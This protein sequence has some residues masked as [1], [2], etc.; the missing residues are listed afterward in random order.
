MKTRVVVVTLVVLVLS[1]LGACGTALA[2]I[3]PEVMT[4]KSFA[5]IYTIKDFEADCESYK[6]EPDADQRRAIR[7]RM[8]H[9]VMAVIARNYG[10]Y[11]SD[12]FAG[13]AATATGFDVINLGMDAAIAITGGKHTKTVL[14]ALATAIHGTGLS[15]DKNFFRD[16]TSESILAMMRAERAR[17]ETEI[18]KK[19]LLEDSKYIFE[20]AWRD[21]VSLFYAGTVPSA[22]ITLASEAGEK[23]T[24]Q[25]DQL[26]GVTRARVAL[27]LLK[28]AESQKLVDNKGKLSRWLRKLRDAD[29][30]TAVA[31]LTGVA[32]SGTNRMAW[33]DAVSMAMLP[34][35]TIKDLENV[36]DKL[37]QGG[38][39][40]VP[41]GN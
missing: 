4:E 8:T 19:L 15:L 2:P 31:A 39:S 7:D 28:L 21:L 32:A 27:P 6:D 18:Q 9:R 41:G 37:K 5:L 3:P 40:G 34:V 22:L 12:F 23:A 1:V 38:L 30:K 11:E 16:K 26:A 14:G 25:Q 13:R 35:A 20:E 33:L 29:L 36:V 10:Q 24:E 17:V